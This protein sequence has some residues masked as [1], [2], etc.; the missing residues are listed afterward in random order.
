MILGVQHDV[1]DAFFLQQLGKALGFLDRSRA[2][3]HGLAGVVQLLDF[4]GSREI[5]FF[6]GAVN[7]VRILHAQHR[8]VGGNDD[9][10]E[11][12]NLVEFRASVSAVPVMPASFLYMRK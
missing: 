2:H 11:A 7:D 9:H 6:F 10:F 5:L 3:Q 1:L 4:V 8:L 12:V